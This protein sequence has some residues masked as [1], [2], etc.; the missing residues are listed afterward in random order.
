MVRNKPSGLFPSVITFVKV[1]VPKILF[2]EFSGMEYT[3][4]LSRCAASSCDEKETEK[5]GF[6]PLHR[7]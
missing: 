1:F 2:K 5:K 4:L 6:E 7:Y 3:V